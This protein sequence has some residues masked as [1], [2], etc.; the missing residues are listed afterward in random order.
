MVCDQIQTS[1][2]APTPH[3]QLYQ[4]WGLGTDGVWIL[5]AHWVWHLNITNMFW[6]WLNISPSGWNWFH[7]RIVAIRSNIC[8][9][10]YVLN[11]FGAPTQVFTHQGIKFSG[12]FQELCEKTLIDHCTTSQDHHEA[13]ML[14]KQMVQMV[15]WGLQKY[16]FHKG[17]TQNWDLWVPWLAIRY[18]FSWQASP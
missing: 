14:T 6:L 12:E 8:I 2:N 7:C 17:H 16:D 15:K 4:L 13:N 1:F 3:L 18:R 10:G 5:L 9:F 11:R